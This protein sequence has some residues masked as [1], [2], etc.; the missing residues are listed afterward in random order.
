M[1]NCRLLY[2][3]AGVAGTAM[4]TRARAVVAAVDKTR[5]LVITVAAVV[6]VAVEVTATKMGINMV[7]HTLTQ[8]VVVVAV[9]RQR[10]TRWKF[11]RWEM[12]SRLPCVVRIARQ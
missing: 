12:Y 4:R 7:T 9:A 5:R 2:L 8:A 11:R 10:P 6:M 3:E 1:V